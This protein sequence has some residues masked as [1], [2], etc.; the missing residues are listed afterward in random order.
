[1]NNTTKRFPGNRSKKI[2]KNVIIITER[3]FPKEEGSFGEGRRE[4]REIKQ[5]VFDERGKKREFKRERNLKRTS[6]TTVDWMDCI[7]VSRERDSDE[8][9]RRCG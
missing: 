7:L 1:V 6:T 5:N 4:R 2:S 9:S 3:D 8:N